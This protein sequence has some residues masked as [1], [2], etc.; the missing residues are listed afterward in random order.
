MAT[1]LRRKTRGPTTT[2]TFARPDKRNALN[3][4]LVGELRRALRKAAEDDTVRTVVLTGAGSVFSAGADLTSL[5]ALQEAS[6]EENLHDSEHLAGLFEEIYRHPKPVIAKVNGHAIGGGAGLAAVCDFAYVAEG[7]K[8]GFTEVRIGFVP[9]VVMVFVRRTLGETSARDLLLRGRLLS[10]KEA[11]EVGLVSNALPPGEL[12]AEVEN[13][14]GELARETSPAAV[15]LT[16]EALAQTDGMG[17]SEALSHATQLNALARS[18]E[19]C[20]AGIAAF[21]EKRDPPWKEESGPGTA[22]GEDSRG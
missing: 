18:T 22:D 12:D 21:L 4:A 3:A 1:L 11:T 20:Q 2:L 16:K 19:D 6:P 14:A 5:E 10:G 13:L 7:A 8:I 17:L 15:R 9:A